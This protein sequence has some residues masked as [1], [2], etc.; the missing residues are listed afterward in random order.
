MVIVSLL[1][2]Y[3]RGHEKKGN[4]Q[5]NSLWKYDIVSTSF[6][7]SANNAAGQT[8]IESSQDVECNAEGDNDRRR[9][10]NVD[11]IGSPAINDWGYQRWYQRMR[12]D[13][14]SKAISQMNWEQ[15]QT[16]SLAK[17]N[18]FLRDAPYEKSVFLG[19]ARIFSD[20]SLSSKGIWILQAY[21]YRT[22]L[23]W[24]W[25]SSKDHHWG[26]PGICRAGVEVAGRPGMWKCCWAT[27][28]FNPP[29][30]KLT[31]YQDLFS[32]KQLTDW[33]SKFLHRI[34]N[35]TKDSF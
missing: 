13:Q 10:A 18:I 35:M 22:S 31:P 29:S 16:T 28:T 8:Q 21:K 30:T 1:L 6:T 2:P 9:G 7:N 33:L 19:S 26:A 5:R 12:P 11:L 24:K 17:D 3:I 27:D 15:G 4:T 23:Y 32:D 25:C 34:K 20:E 14:L